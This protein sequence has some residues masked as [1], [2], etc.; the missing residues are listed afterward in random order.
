MK[1]FR[2][3]AAVLSVAVLSS[4]TQQQGQVGGGQP[5]NFLVVVLDD[6]G[7]ET[8]ECYGPPVATVPTPR[9]SALAATGVRFTHAYAN[10]VCSATRAT[11]LTGR[12]AFRTG[13][14]FLSSALNPEYEDYSLPLSE[15]TI[16]EVLTGPVQPVPPYTCGAFGKWHL[17]D[18]ANL[19]HPI[20]QGFDLFA[21]SIENTGSHFN[22]DLIVADSTGVTS[23]HIG[24]PYPTGVYTEATFSA[25]VVRQ[26]AS[27]WIANVPEPFFAYVCFNP[28]HAPWQVP[29]YSLLSAATLAS[30]DP[31]VYP[32]GSTQ[33][34]PTDSRKAYGWMLE[35][36]DTEV[37]HLVDSIPAAKRARTT[38]LVVADNGTP[39]TV[40][41]P[42]Y[43][44]T[45]AK[46]S[47]F[48]QGVNVP[49][50]ANG[51]KVHAGGLTCSGL[52][53][54]VDFLPTVVALAKLPAPTGVT[55]DGVSFKHMLANPSAAS[56]RAQAFAQLYTPSGPYDPNLYPDDC[57][58]PVLL[59]SLSLHR[60]AMT[61]GRY[62]Y[63]RRYDAPYQQAFDL[64]V[65]PLELND[66]WVQWGWSQL[67]DPCS[68]PSQALPGQAEVWTLRDSM[69]A[70][71]AP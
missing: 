45:H 70:L 54:T 14:G 59:Q 39:G 36:I 41:D 11:L 32:A 17:T 25:S 21:G 7:I 55:I 13:M 35:A 63:V 66:L 43:D 8:L 69:V 16:P 40:I 50:I 29:P 48:E 47:V 37:G 65:D 53:N 38:I 68:V 28:P 46:G 33:S 51:H 44:P 1:C 67:A 58:P 9:L 42:F 5:H 4:W 64:L 49:L 18:S 71:S 10:P 62:K 27:T 23:T 56:N 6:V 61:D 12:F 30:F 60:R 57:A 24:H 20:D 2:I 19:T 52:V 26:E 34:G 15:R 3:G 22:W 31:A